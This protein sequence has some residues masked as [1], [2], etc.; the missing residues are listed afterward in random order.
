MTKLVR[1]KSNE[2]HHLF[3]I[4]DCLESIM[5]GS[6]PGFHQWDKHALLR[7]AG[8]EI[9]IPSSCIHQKVMLY[10]EPDNVTDPSFYV[11]I[12]YQRRHF[13]VSNV[14]VPSYPEAGDMLLVKGDNPEP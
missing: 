4:G 12:D 14:I 5:Y 13:P 1:I 10:P 7:P 11:C 2:E 9:K 3:A 6:D 8:V